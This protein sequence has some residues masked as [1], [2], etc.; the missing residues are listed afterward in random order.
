VVP[1]TKVWDRIANVSHW[2]EA[3]GIPDQKGCMSWT[4]FQ[5]YQDEASGQIRLQVRKA[6][7]SSQDDDPWRGLV[8]GTEYHDVFEDISVLPP[9]M[10]AVGPAQRT[11]PTSDGDHKKLLGGLKRL[12]AYLEMSKTSVAKCQALIEA[13]HSTEDLP[14]DWENKDLP[15]SILPADP[16]AA[17]PDPILP[18]DPAAAQL[19][20]A[21]RQPK[22]KKNKK[23]KKSKRKKRKRSEEGGGARGR[24][25]E[26]EMEIDEWEL[27]ID[28]GVA[29]RP[30]DSDMI[31]PVWLGCVVG[32]P[33]TK[34][35]DF[36]VHWRVAKD[37]CKVG[38][39]HEYLRQAF[40]TVM[41][42]RGPNRSGA[43]AGPKNRKYTDMQ[44]QKDIVMK[45]RFTKG[46]VLQS[47]YAESLLR[48]VAELA[49]QPE[50]EAE[51][52]PSAATEE[53]DQQVAFVPPKRN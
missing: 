39:E 44:S 40:P 9:G 36:K 2:V 16:A 49:G 30:R 42:A 37:D 43:K 6:C 25:E 3:M 32:V 50:T 35:G 5:Y 1:I 20:E 48:K 11:K 53:Q 29:L 45:V 52:T 13:M 26:L 10:E 31:E 17:R 12:E 22:N 18:K 8:D 51:P 27:A 28:D 46:N 24:E 41:I 34:G 14:F 15:T 4:Q 23:N 21:K 19:D 47:G 7:G 33:D 38:E